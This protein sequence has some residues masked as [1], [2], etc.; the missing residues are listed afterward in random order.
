[1]AVSKKI[2]KMLCGLISDIQI[3]VTKY[4]YT[5]LYIY[6]FIILYNTY[7]YLYF[8][9]FIFLITVIFFC[10]CFGFLKDICQATNL[11][12]SVRRGNC[13]CRSCECVNQEIISIKM[14][15][16]KQNAQIAEGLSRQWP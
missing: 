16:E 9:L 8:Y 5:Y 13:N 2:I 11:T 15:E 10:C 3:G 12:L 14:Y 4:E 1:M 7:M 6:M